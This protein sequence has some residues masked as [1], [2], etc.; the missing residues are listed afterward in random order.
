MRH[1][2]YQVDELDNPEPVNLFQQNRI[3]QVVP[4]RPGQVNG[5]ALPLLR[6]SR[7][8]APNPVISTLRLSHAPTIGREIMFGC[9]KIGDELAL[10]NLQ[11]KSILYTH[12]VSRTVDVL[13]I[14]LFI[15]TSDEDFDYDHTVHYIR[16]G[17]FPNFNFNQT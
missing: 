12:H 4:I 5:G 6:P 7:I 15:G 14:K 17:T 9:P 13:I 11:A 8:V 16:N 3:R 1:L 2:G 10:S